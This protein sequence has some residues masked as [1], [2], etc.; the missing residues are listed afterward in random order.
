MDSH[1]LNKG[2]KE[3]RTIAP[4]S[5]FWIVHACNTYVCKEKKRGARQYK[6]KKKR[7]TCARAQL[8]VYKNVF[9]F[10][11]YV[12]LLYF[13]WHVSFSR[14]CTNFWWSVIKRMKRGHFK[15]K[16]QIS[17]THALNADF[18]GAWRRLLTA[19]ANSH[20]SALQIAYVV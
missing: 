15:K 16:S 12:I 10:T 1:E 7:N 11:S 5:Q 19:P 8:I 9:A 2:Q 20:S 6:N 17:G 4:A 14:G 13:L 3:N 18:L